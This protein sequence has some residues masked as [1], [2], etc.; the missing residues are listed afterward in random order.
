MTTST[1]IPDEFIQNL[2]SRIDI[3][4]V[5]GEYVP[6]RKAGANYM[7]CCP[8]HNEKTPSFSVNHSKQFYH[9][10]GCGVSGDVIQFVIEKNGLNFVEAIELLAGQAGLQMPQLEHNEKFAEQNLIYT[11]LSEASSFYAK[12]LREHPVAKNAVQYLKDR[13]LTGIVAKRFELGF[14]PP[15]WDNLLHSFPAETQAKDTG[16]T[17]GLLVHRD[18]RYYDRFRNRI[19]FPIRNRRGN[20]I[21]FGG[22]TIGAASNEEPK[23]LN[24]PETPVF[25][26]G[27]E[28]YGIYEAKQA[29]AHA[30]QVIVV[31][32][33]MD[34]VSMAQAGINNIVATLG[35]A[36][37]EHHIKQLF[38]MAHE[39]IF[40][41][42]GD[43]AGRKA[44]W[45]ALELC[46]PVLDDKHRI[47]FL[48]LPNGNDPD[49]YVRAHG[50]E[51]MQRQIK[52]AISLADYLFDTLTKDADLQ[53]IDDRVRVANNIKEHLLKL[54]DGLFK[55]MLFDRLG[56]II[57]VDPAKLH[58]EVMQPQHRW[59]EFSQT[60]VHNQNN[61]EQS[62]ILVSPA[63][64]ALALLFSHREL[65]Q[66][67]PD[68][69][70]IEKIDIAGC[71]LL[72]AVAQ[73]LQK[74]PAI[75][76]DQ[77]KPLLDA[78]LGKYF[79]AAQLRGIARLVPTGGFEQEFLGAVG[80]L[81]KRENE[82][83]LDV[84][85]TKAKQDA[86]SAEDKQ[87]LQSLL[88]GMD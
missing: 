14:A 63:M 49:S 32:G 78:K 56:S 68:L 51:V 25:N 60:V 20:V 86:L 72:C 77:V 4:E 67:L 28:L 81:R 26:K 47:K 70:G 65:L 15:G 38:K 57:K 16:V 37:T 35:T 44:A 54:P 13:G 64:R 53:Q 87:Q 75:E 73:I 52:Q 84:L 45:R 17:A 83:A 85:L 24:S 6:L 50:L 3:V 71:K 21:G 23:Y 7:A 46:L 9:C 31:E 12:Q 22:R 62:L 58:K 69:T 76:D 29:I 5:I 41:F 66:K 36:C 55:T 43:N 30:D 74:N 59:S 19:M 8:F 88:K 40:C 42:D 82:L 10:F 61:Q 48:L 2:L 39:I 1:R 80:L 33:Y 11:V 34:V 79:I 18:N 27:H